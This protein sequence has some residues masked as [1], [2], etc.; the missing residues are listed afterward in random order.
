MVGVVLFGI[1]DDMIVPMQV[2][3]HAQA[4]EQ[5]NTV[6]EEIGTNKQKKAKILERKAS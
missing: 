2:I 4:K 1:E 3:T 6:M 5:P